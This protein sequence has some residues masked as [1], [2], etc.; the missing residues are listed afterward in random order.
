MKA[1]RSTSK[2]SSVAGTSKCTAGLQQPQARGLRGLRNLGNTCYINVVLQALSNIT[3]FRNHYMN[4]L[5]RLCSPVSRTR[6]HHND[7]LPLCA[8]M[9]QLLRFLW[10]DGC[11]MVPEKVHEIVKAIFHSSKVPFSQLQVFE[12]QDAQE[13]LVFLLQALQQECSTAR[14]HQNFI[15]DTFQGYLQYQTICSSCGGVTKCDQEFLDLRLPLASVANGDIGCSLY[16][17]LDAFTREEPVAGKRPY[18]CKTCRGMQAASRRCRFSQLPKVLVL[19]V[20]RI[21][22]Q[23][24]R[25]A[26]QTKI[27]T[28]LQFPLEEELDLQHFCTA[29]LQREQQ[30]QSHTYKLAAV[31]VHHGR[32]VDQGHYT[33]LCRHSSSHWF[34]FNDHQVTEIPPEAVAQTQAYIL[35]YE[36][37]IRNKSVRKRGPVDEPEELGHGRITRHRA[38]SSQHAI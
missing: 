5:R 8:N 37:V 33:V 26:T 20:N 34:E 23:M 30:T 11:A 6:S 21:Q 10:G 3:M 17:C 38:T 9:Q 27:R 12:Q 18:N 7:A 13:F 29:S 22:C 14:P 24:R 31:V 36:A 16:E 4:E 1:G 28:H 2:Y 15:N 32:A 19:Q 25:I 35:I